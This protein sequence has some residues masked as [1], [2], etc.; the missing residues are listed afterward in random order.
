MTRKKKQKQSDNSGILFL[1]VALF[2][3]YVFLTTD[4]SK[5]NLPIPNIMPKTQTTD[6]WVLRVFPEKSTPKEVQE[7]LNDNVFWSSLK[8]KG[9]AGYMDV[10]SDNPEAEE[11]IKKSGVK[12]P[13]I[14]LVSPDKRK[15]LWTIPF[16]RGSTD[17]IK[18]ELGL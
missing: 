12:P 3:G 17:P 4:L 13:S 18:R 6:C 14:M 8:E 10:N 5:F 2:L 11:L 15:L 1:V 16:P 7:I 9:L